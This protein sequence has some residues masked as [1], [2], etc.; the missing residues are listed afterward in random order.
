[1]NPST[2]HDEPQLTDEVSNYVDLSTATFPADTRQRLH[3]KGLFTGVA[4]RSVKEIVVVT[5]D[6]MS[7]IK[8]HLLNFVVLI[9]AWLDHFRALEPA[10]Q[11]T[12]DHN[13]SVGA[14]ASIR[15]FKS[16]KGDSNIKV[17]SLSQ[18]ACPGGG[19]CK[20]NTTMN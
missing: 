10:W 2:V 18:V 3:E 4:T 1:M 7:T 15:T 6:Q 17:K 14:R 19:S 8:W 5:Q 9:H 11:C 20:Y 12:S 13:D 16:F